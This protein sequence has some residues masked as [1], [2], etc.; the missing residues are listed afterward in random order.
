MFIGGIVSGHLNVIV[1][2][3]IICAFCSVGLA[4]YTYFLYYKSK[5]FNLIDNMESSL[6]E[7]KIV[8]V[9]EGNRMRKRE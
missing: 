4:T 2:S 8:Y 9:S 7:S 1:E 5:L 3:L 6:N